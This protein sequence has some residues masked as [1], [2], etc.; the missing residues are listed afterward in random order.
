MRKVL[1]WGV[2]LAGLGVARAQTVAAVPKLDLTRM[3]TTWYEIAHSPDK[4][5]KKCV[6]DGLVLF[7]SGEKV[8]RLEEVASCVYKN[9]FANV[10]NISLRL[11][12]KK[13]MDGRLQTS[14]LFLF[15]RKQW[16]L[17][18]DDD[19]AWALIGSPNHK[20]L[21]VLSRTSTMAPEVLEVVKAKASAQGFEVSKL[22]VVPQTK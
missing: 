17:A 18:L 22:M 5:E 15:H 6:R 12:D 3:A 10:Q 20:Q 4:A 16:V 19:Y 8:G 1:A 7:A 13:V 9:G 11:K 2:L 21:W 14:F